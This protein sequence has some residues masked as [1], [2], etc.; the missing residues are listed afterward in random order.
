MKCLFLTLTCIFV[1]FYGNA[2]DKKYTD[3]AVAEYIE[4]CKCV[5]KSHD[6]KA[7]DYERIRKTDFY[8]YARKI[9]YISFNNTNPANQ[10]PYLKNGFLDDDVIKEKYFL[11]S[12]EIDSLNKTLFN[13]KY[14]GTPLKI[15]VFDCSI[16]ENAI[17]YLDEN[18]KP[19]AALNIC[20][21]GTGYN[22]WVSRSYKGTHGPTLWDT[23]F[24][25]YELLA[26]LFRLAG[27]K[28]LK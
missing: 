18:N 12:S 5:I 28:N 13:Y 10:T 26:R 15:L 25:K 6:G 27:I 1:Y 9:L 17:V 3:S 23:C 22:V 14:K 8:K 19:I 4:A 24:G 20:F 2:Q 21:S 16:P 11:S 7:T